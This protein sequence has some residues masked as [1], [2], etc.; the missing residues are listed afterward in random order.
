MNENQSKNVEVEMNFNSSVVSAVGRNE[1]IVIVNSSE[2]KQ[3][4]LEFV[5]ETKKL[6]EQ[7]ELENP[8]ATDLNKFSLIDSAI[9]PTLK[10]RTISAVK[11]G[12][13]SA[14]DEFI[15]E[16]KYLKVAKSVI[17]AWIGPS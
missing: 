2:N 8:Q 10:K 3:S 1:G 4:L 11:A 15:L 12:S 17:K 5:I 9:S 14:I 7:L 13:E 16:N 6:L